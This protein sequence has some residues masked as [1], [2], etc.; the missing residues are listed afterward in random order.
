MVK[1]THVRIDRQSRV[2]RT[3]WPFK[4]FAWGP[5]EA[6]SKLRFRGGT[7]RAYIHHILERIVE[8]TILGISRTTGSALKADQ[9]ESARIAHGIIVH[10]AIR[11]Q[12]ALP[13]VGQRSVYWRAKTGIGRH[14]ERLA[15]LGRI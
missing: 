6:S 8:D 2:V 15:I 3:E 14:V 4:G 10:Y 5:A 1:L 12:R 13:T 11:S 7:E 9:G